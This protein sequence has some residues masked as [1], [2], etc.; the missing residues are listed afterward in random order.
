GTAPVIP[1]DREES[2][3]IIYGASEPGFIRITEE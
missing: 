3:D 1:T 2:P